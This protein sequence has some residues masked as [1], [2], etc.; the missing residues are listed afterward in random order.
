MTYCLAIKVKT[1]LVALADTRL[2]SGSEFSVAR[3]ISV[4]R[5]DKHSL[6]IMTS[7]LRSVRDKAITY[8]TE[9]IEDGTA[10]Y[11]K[12]YKA[13]NALAAQI[14]A[15]A[16]EDKAALAES[17]LYFNLHAIIGGQLENDR[18]PKLYL[19]YPEGNW[20]EV[21]ESSPYFSIGNYGYGK[22]VLVRSLTYDSSIEFALKTGFLSFDA[23]IRSC[24][25]V[26]YPIDVAI[27]ENNSYTIVEHRFE[28][29]DLESIATEWNKGVTE[30]INRMPDA[31]MQPI[32]EKIQHSHLHQE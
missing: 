9:A 22:P 18:E 28:E 14:R 11:D 20:V 16:K 32:V 13:V 25:D 10:N 27:Y 1:G 17:G 8:F 15:V 31:W 7:G 5:R 24:N 3:K 12:L 6:F 30:S 19:L 26:G 21:G 23:T 2:T 4:H 29:S